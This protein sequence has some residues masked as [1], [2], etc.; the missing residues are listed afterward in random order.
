MNRNSAIVG[1]L[2]IVSLALIGIG[3][4]QFGSGQG[5]ASQAP[6]GPTP[7]IDQVRRITVQDLHRRLQ[8]ANPPLVWELRSAEVFAAG[9]ILGSRSVQF[10]E[11]PALAQSLDRKQALII[12]CA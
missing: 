6:S 2:V 8:V 4:S 12:L 11:V 9:H 7:T 10:S 5:S 3:I 1:V